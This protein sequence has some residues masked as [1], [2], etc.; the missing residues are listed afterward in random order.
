MVKKQVTLYQNILKLTFIPMLLLFLIIIDEPISAETITVDDNGGADYSTIQDAINAANTSDTIQV[1]SGTYSENIQINKTLIILGSGK[2]NTF[3]IGT[4]SSQN[5]VKITADQVILSG[6]SIDNNQGQPNQYHCIFIQLADYC[7]ISEN[8]IKNG[9]NGIYL[10]SSNNNN[11]QE[12]IIKNNNQKGLRL[13]SSNNNNISSNTLQSNGDGIYLSTSQSNEIYE[14][15]IINNVIGISLSVVSNNNIVYRNDFDDNTGGNAEDVGL[16]YWSKNNQGNYWDDYNDYDSN[17]DGIGDNPYNIDQDSFD[18]YPLGDFLTSN[19]IPVA[20][21]DSISPNP[22]IHGDLVSFHGHGVDDGTIIAWE[23]KSSK[24]GIFGTSADCNYDGLSLGTHTI[25]FRVK[26]DELQW[27]SYNTAILTIQSET[28]QSTNERP[29]ASILSIIPNE[30]NI[31]EEVKFQ[32]LGTDIDGTIIAYQWRSSIDG[33]LSQQSSFSLTTLSEGVHMIYFK[34][35][36]NN[37]TWSIED[38]MIV[39][40]KNPNSPN[41]KPVSIALIPTKGIVNKPLLFDGS[42]SH[43]I[44]GNITSY[45]WN[46]GDNT[47]GEGKFITHTYNNTGNYTVSLTVTDNIGKTNTFNSTVSIAFEADNNNTNQN[48]KNTPSFTILTMIISFGFI[49]LLKRKKRL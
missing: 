48:G 7:T 44:D 45:E 9:E 14:N 47:S 41:E 34:V 26:D 40:V 31:T 16:N 6:F 11:I 42:E 36:D 5:T 1:E 38:S 23:W 20:V 21:I 12:N 22:S 43:D 46:F 24:N 27:S 19:E 25:L 39:S 18:N 49:I 32:G 17:E 13:S 10:I 37:D 35:K 30:L 33:M 28:N 2:S 15:T 4:Q 3:I 8:I 29:I